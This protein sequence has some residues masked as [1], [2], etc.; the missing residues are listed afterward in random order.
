MATAML[1]YIDCTHSQTKPE[2]IEI[3]S[4]R[5]Y[6][7]R[8]ARHLRSVGTLL[9]VPETNRTVTMRIDSPYIDH[10]INVCPIRNLLLRGESPV[11]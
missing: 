5:M 11:A 10:G 4:G 7:D 3:K 8:F 9:N 1:W 6:H 2:L